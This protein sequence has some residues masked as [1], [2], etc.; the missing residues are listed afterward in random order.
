MRLK[1][2]TFNMENLFQRPMAMS[3]EHDADG[4]QAIE[5]HAAANGIA[6]KTIYTQADKD[7][8]VTLSLKYGWHKLNAPSDSLVFLQKVRGQ[9]FSQAGGRLH[10]KANG[11][12][13]W[14]GWFELRKE[15]VR[16]EATF[17][18]G[19]VIAETN[20][21]ILIMVEVENRPTFKHFNEQ[22]LKTEFKK[23]FPHFLV[24]DGNDDRGID[25]GIA[26]RFPVTNIVSHVDDIDPKTKKPVFSR[27]CPE[28]EIALPGGKSIV[29]LPNHFKSKRSG[30]D[31]VSKNKRTAQSKRANVIAQTALAR[32][33]LVLIAGDLNDTPDSA[34]ISHIFDG[35]FTDVMTHADYPNDRPGTFN[36]GLA[37]NKIDYLV[38]SPE[39]RAGL[40]TAG[41]ERRGSFH[42]NTWTPFDT[43]KNKTME[44]SDHHLVWAEF[45][46]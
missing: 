32:T 27:D 3:M 2:A 42:P 22:V 45:E 34:P 40:K 35:G 20:P 41:I 26:S 19:R 1:I 14:V 37:S 15:D 25:V 8:L 7:I 36:T 17:N 24:I 30:D 29:V 13:D 44:A 4:R 5:D 21:D 28:Y 39:L 23:A 31:T 6:G 10:V 18:T 11:R 33:N 43:V 9:L 46:I 38:M 16:W 12:A